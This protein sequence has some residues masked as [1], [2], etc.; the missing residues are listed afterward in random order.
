M[1]ITIKCVQAGLKTHLTPHPADH[2]PLIYLHSNHVIK[3]A[4]IKKGSDIKKRKLLFSTSVH[5]G[6][7]RGHN[8]GQKT[9]AAAWLLVWTKTLCVTPLTHTQKQRGLHIKKVC[10]KHDI[11]FQNVA[12]FQCFLWGFFVFCVRASMIC[13]FVCISTYEWETKVSL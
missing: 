1:E 13:L 3:A 6:Q 10:K 11:S 9:F 2:F 8:S 5:L 7:M 4:G 12:K